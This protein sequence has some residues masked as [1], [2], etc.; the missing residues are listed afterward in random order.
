SYT[1]RTFKKVNPDAKP[2]DVV[3]SQEANS[4]GPVLV[5]TLG[6][7]LQQFDVKIS[8]STDTDL[9]DSLSL[10]FLDSQKIVEAAF[11][12]LNPQS[13]VS[14]EDMAS[15]LCIATAIAIEDKKETLDPTAAFGLAVMGFIEGTKTMPAVIE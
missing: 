1:F 14:N 15:I 7:T 9:S 5:Q 4:K 6:L 3:L 11:K 2:G 10:E 8:K 12:E 13:N